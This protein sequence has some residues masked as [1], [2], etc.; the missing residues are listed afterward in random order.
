M[1][2]VEPGTAPIS[3]QP[4]SSSTLGLK[5]F[6]QT[7]KAL[8]IIGSIAGAG[9]IYLYF[10]R[11]AA[12]AAS[13][14]GTASTNTGQNA[15][16]IAPG[17]DTS[18]LDSDPL[19]SEFGTSLD[20]L[21][22]TVGDIQSNLAASTTST[23]NTG[24]TTAAPATPAAPTSSSLAPSYFIGE[25]LPHGLPGEA[26]AAETPTVDHRGYYYLTSLGGV[27]TQGDAQLGKQYGG[28]YQ[29]Y[30][31]YLQK[32]DPSVYKENIAAKDQDFSG[33]KISVSGNGY[34]ITDNNGNSYTYTF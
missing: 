21:E 4:Q 28:S 30:L 9:G 12:N 27:Y 17:T 16:E 6:Y 33:G 1:T 2:F 23:A 8:V 15:Y 13:S 24:T 29:G 22:Q 10:K 34:T 19:S 3:S 31:N 32:A 26:I 11:R 18:N 7:H 5:A 20:Q 14:A 25:A